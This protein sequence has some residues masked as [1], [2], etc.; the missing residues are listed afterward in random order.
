[1]KINISDLISKKSDEIQVNEKVVLNNINRGGD[2][3]YL[4]D[5]VEVK[6]KVFRVDKDIIFSGLLETI[7]QTECSRCLNNV[8]KDIR[9]SFDE[10][11]CDENTIRE[12]ADILLI[13]EC[14]DLK[15]FSEKLLILKLPMKFLCSEDCK[16]LCLQCGTNLNNSNCN[17][18]KED[19]DIRLIKLKE[20][21]KQ[22]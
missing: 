12:D 3:F 2:I 10:N 20:L 19:I 4:K 14:I 11:V 5:P 16:G 18:E 22:D 1:M 21:L 7:V 8:L 6:G 15:E 9:I 13:D 17:C